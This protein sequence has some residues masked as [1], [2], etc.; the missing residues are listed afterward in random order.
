[1]SKV[2]IEN[3]NN[4]PDVE[5]FKMLEGSVI[6]VG[7]RKIQEAPSTEYTHHLPNNNCASVDYL[8]DGIFAWF[9]IC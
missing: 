9:M 7:P 4:H 6:L 1:M 3:W 2:L 5:H 8:I